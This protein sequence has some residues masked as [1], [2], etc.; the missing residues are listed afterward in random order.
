MGRADLRAVADLHLAALPPSFFSRLGPRFLRAYYET[1]VAGPDA[2]ALAAV[3]E[4]L[5]CGYVV[6]TA[7]AHDHAAWTA[8]RRGVRLA[9][10][11]VTCM[12]GRPRVAVEFLRTRVGRY[13]RGLARR[14]R[15]R[16]VGPTAAA[17]APADGR[18]PAVL[19][20]VAVHD[21]S[22]G[23][24]TGELLV[25][26]FAAELSGR[27]VHRFDLVTLAGP[28]GAAGFY[29]R[30]GLVATGQRVDPDGRSWRSF[31]MTTPAA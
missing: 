26:R 21:R 10:V 22:R 12:A 7:A 2:V 31:R 18:Q 27:G 25:R 8:R 23:T 13:A 1:Y 4:G 17:A 16:P 29:E 19:S 15:H 11:A 14:L 30:L 24:G 5:L 28:D 20:H 6:G 3:R 9:L